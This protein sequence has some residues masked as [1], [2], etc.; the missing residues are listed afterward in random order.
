[1]KELLIVATVIVAG[2]KCVQLYNEWEEPLASK[3][4]RQSL[5][6]AKRL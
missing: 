1:M 5:L 4:L 2:I 6:A 3:V